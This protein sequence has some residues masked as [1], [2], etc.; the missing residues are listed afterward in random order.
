VVCWLQVHIWEPSGQRPFEGKFP[1]GFPVA[2]AAAALSLDSEVDW[3]RRYAI[4]SSRSAAGGM[5]R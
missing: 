2:D 1:P 5:G 4:D 3:I